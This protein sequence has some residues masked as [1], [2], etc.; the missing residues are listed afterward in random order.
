MLEEALN[1][2]EPSK[3]IGLVFTQDD[4]SVSSYCAYGTYGA[5]PT[6]SPAAQF[7]LGARD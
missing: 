3:V 1:A 5:R 6:R 2:M 4:R 7:A